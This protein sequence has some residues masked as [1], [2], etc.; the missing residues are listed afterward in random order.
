VGRKE[1]R[2]AL[3]SKPLVERIPSDWLDGRDVLLVTLTDQWVWPPELHVDWFTAFVAADARGV[4]DE[5]I[6]S[7]A[8]AMLP[9]HCAHVTTWGPDC[10]RVHHLF[11]E[12]YLDAAEPKPHRI[13][14]WRTSWPV[15]IPFL[16][17][18]SSADESLAE[19]LWYAVYVAWPSGDGYHESRPA[20]LVALVQPQFR[21]EVRGLLLD[22]DRL[23]RETALKD[24][25][26]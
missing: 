4:N 24:E 22:P 16:M 19:A 12:A 14:R 17:T 2:R 9:H 26:G 25:E 11:D 3:L 7:L 18:S 8:A 21:D 13:L 23:E 15:H 20:D 5:T 6:H 1:P 10:E